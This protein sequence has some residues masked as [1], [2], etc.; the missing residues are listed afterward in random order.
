MPIERYLS[1]KEIREALG[2]SRSNAYSIMKELPRVKIGSSIRVSES[3]F[4]LWLKR[5]TIQPAWKVADVDPPIRLT[6]PRTRA[7]AK[8]ALEDDKPI[9]RMAPRT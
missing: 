1:A 3:A 9:R 6:R 4:E 7:A 5:Q 8:K 2:I